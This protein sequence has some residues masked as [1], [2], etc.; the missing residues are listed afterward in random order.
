MVH[1]SGQEKYLKINYWMT[2]GSSSACSWYLWTSTDFKI[3]ILLY[4]ISRY[5]DDDK[6][7]SQVDDSASNSEKG[8]RGQLVSAELTFLPQLS[9][10]GCIAPSSALTR[11]VLPAMVLGRAASVVPYPKSVWIHVAESV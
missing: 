10:E 1:A 7:T 4:E 9:L 11:V 5:N 3:S 8:T 2:I 6:L